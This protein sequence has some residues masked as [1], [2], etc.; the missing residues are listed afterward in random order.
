MLESSASLDA[1]CG[2]AQIPCLSKSF[3]DGGI[4]RCAGLSINLVAKAI[5]YGEGISEFNK[6]IIG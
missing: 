6:A 1:E 4:S 2:E 3:K 5:L